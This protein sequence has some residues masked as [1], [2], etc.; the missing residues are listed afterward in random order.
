MIL[1]TVK[2]WRRGSQVSRA[3][4]GSARGRDSWMDFSPCLREGRK[5]KKLRNCRRNKPESGVKL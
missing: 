1:L 5:T 2:R 4:S 3:F